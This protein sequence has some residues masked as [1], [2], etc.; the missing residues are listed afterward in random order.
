MACASC[1]A[2]AAGGRTAGALRR[3]VVGS[4][5]SR[6]MG[7][8]PVFNA[9]ARGNGTAQAGAPMGWRGGTRRGVEGS[10]LLLL[11]PSFLP[12]V[13]A[14]HSLAA[15]FPD[16]SLSICSHVTTSSAMP[17]GQNLEQGARSTPGVSFQG[18]CPHHAALERGHERT[19]SPLQWDST[20]GKSHV[21]PY[22]AQRPPLH[23][24]RC[25]RGPRYQERAAAGVYSAVASDAE[26][27]EG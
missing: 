13:P 24:Q 5:G 25:T 10:L 14:G 15:A 20:E 8:V 23:T 1:P 3:E 6:W 12:D 17:W 18:C 27:M 19:G 4:C 2:P 11:A 22:A 26:A 21:A 7:A 9:A 16:P